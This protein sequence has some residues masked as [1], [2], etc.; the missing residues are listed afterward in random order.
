LLILRVLSGELPVTAAITAAKM[1]RGRYYQL[2]TRALEG[3]LAALQPVA[4]GRTAAAPAAGHR[5]AQL[6][7]KLTALEAARRRAER[8]LG[9]TRK[10]TRLRPRSTSPG[11]PASRS[12][13]RTT[14][15]PAP[16]SRSMPPTTGAGAP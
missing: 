4:R 11:G 14:G 5:Q 12:S 3:M 6:E 2:E 15:A 7:A 8:L 10:L 9:V 13:R 16:G 1:S